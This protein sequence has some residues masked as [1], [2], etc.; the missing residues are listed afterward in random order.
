MQPYDI[1][2]LPRDTASWLKVRFLAPIL[3]VEGGW[4]YWIQIDFPCWL[5]TRGADP[6]DF[7]REYTLDHV[8]L[9]W[10]INA[11]FGANMVAVNIKAQSHKYQTDRLLKDVTADVA[12]LKSIRDKNIA[13]KMIVAVVDRAAE[14]ALSE[15]GFKTIYD[16]PDHS[17]A[18]MSRDVKP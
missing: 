14:K 4:E 5:D 8:R 10:I 1:A 16:A 3:N 17:F 6:F 18:I 11:T 9:D 2:N 15:D 13:R 7:R 12:K